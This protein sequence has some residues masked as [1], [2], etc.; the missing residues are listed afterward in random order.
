MFLLSICVLYGVDDVILRRN[1]G[2]GDAGGAKPELSGVALGVGEVCRPCDFRAPR[3]D[4]DGHNVRL[5]EPGH[6]DVDEFGM[7]GYGRIR[8]PAGRRDGEGY[9]AVD[10]LLFV[11]DAVDFIDALR[12]RLCKI[13]YGSPNALDFYVLLKNNFC[14]LPGWLS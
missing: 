13:A 3:R 11:Q 8:T 5:K 6:C 1:S 14:V 2:R 12:G 7:L 10:V 4:I 9:L